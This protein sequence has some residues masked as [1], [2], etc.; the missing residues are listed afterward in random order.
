MLGDPREVDDRGCWWPSPPILIGSPVAGSPVPSAALAGRLDV[1]RPLAA[2]GSVSAPCCGRRPPCGRRPGRGG[3]RAA[4]SSARRRGGARPARWSPRRLDAA[5]SWPPRRRRR[6]RRTRRARA[7]RLPRVPAVN[8]SCAPPLAGESPTPPPSGRVGGKVHR[9]RLLGKVSRSLRC[10]DR[11]HVPRYPSFA[12]GERR[13]WSASTR[14][15]TLD[16]SRDEPG[17]LAMADTS[18]GVGVGGRAARRQRP[19]AQRRRGVP[20]DGRG[21]RRPGPP[22]PRRR[23]R[24]AVGLDRVAVP[25]AQLAPGVRGLPARAELPPEAAAAADPRRRVAGHAALRRPRLRPGRAL[26]V[27]R[28]RPPQARRPDPGALPVPGVAA[29]AA[30][31]DRRVRRPRGPGRASSRST[32]RASSTS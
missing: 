18:D 9:R 30:G 26:V 1:A 29:D 15:R 19:A 8:A 24:A 13:A 3:R 23:D 32:R 12:A 22:A 11:E 16:T 6:R 31:A 2:G 27:R 14:G 10:S 5:A 21:A 4:V 25:G 28:V 17:G 7:R 20:G